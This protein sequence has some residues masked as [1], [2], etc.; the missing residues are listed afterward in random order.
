MR[1]RSILILVAAIAAVVVV[2]CGDDDGG[3]G[4]T[5]AAD[6]TTTTAGALTIEMGDFYFDPKDVTAEA[7]PATI[8]APNVGQVVHELVL[9]KTDADPASLP[10]SGPE[11]DEAA[12]EEQ[13]AVLAGEIEDVEAGHTK[14]GSFDL[15]AGKYV[16]FCNIPTHY[17]QG[18]YGSV[19][20]K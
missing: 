10:V 14:S 13:G 11:V 16:M 19:T 3:D 20:V 4:G 15:T 9:F 7:G 2:G 12:L 1:Y 8:D 18:M 6:T 17:G 5:T